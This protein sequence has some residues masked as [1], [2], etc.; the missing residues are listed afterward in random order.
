MRASL[1]S[2]LVIW[3]ISSRAGSG[4]IGAV[5]QGGVSS[6]P[7][8]SVYVLSDELGGLRPAS[9]G[10][11]C[12]LRPRVVVRGAAQF[13][14]EVVA[15]AAPASVARAKALLFA[16]GRLAG[17]GERV[18]LELSVEVLLSEA[19]IE[20]F[21]LVG[22]EGL[23]PASVRTLRTN[24]RALARVVQ[25]YPPPVPTPRPAG[26][27][28]RRIRWR[29]SPVSALGAGVEHTAAAHA[30]ECAGVSGR[31]RGDHRGGAA[32]RARQ[33]RGGALGRDDRLRLR[34]GA[35]GA[36]PGPLPAAPIRGR[37]VRGRELHRGRAGAGPAQHHRRALPRALERPL[38]AAASERAAEVE[39]ADRVR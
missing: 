9:L 23:S 26:A 10:R 8:R 35:I 1:V 19:V 27:R 38:A 25:R 24:L 30:R 6:R 2:S 34:P 16:A 20:R 29:R 17:F 37:G 5:W 11:D 21:V 36:G 13:A 18:G 15:L 31:G 32:S 28:R 22:C 7:R 39:L 4:L 3:R 14:R 33:R 12:R